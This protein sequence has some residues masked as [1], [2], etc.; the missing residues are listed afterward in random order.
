MTHQASIGSCTPAVP[1]DL[2]RQVHHHQAVLPRNDIQVYFDSTS[3]PCIDIVLAPTIRSHP[4]A[5]SFSDK[6]NHLLLGTDEAKASHQ[7]RHR[8]GGHHQAGHRRGEGRLLVWADEA[9]HLHHRTSTS[10]RYAVEHH[11]SDG[12][13][14]PSCLR[15]RSTYP[16]YEWPSKTNR[17]N[18]ASRSLTPWKRS[19]IMPC[20]I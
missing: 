8:Q 3:T 10:R 20:R 9:R 1:Q 11:R 14:V 18:C 6:D 17:Y 15:W 4:V 12:L 5:M 2:H 13:T 7:V 16:L 19:V